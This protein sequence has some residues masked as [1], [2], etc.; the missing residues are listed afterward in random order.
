MDMRMF[1]MNGFEAVASIR[2]EYPTARIVAFEHV[3]RG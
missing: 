1:G 3:W 2:A